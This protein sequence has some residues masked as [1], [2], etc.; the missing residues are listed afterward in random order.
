[1]FTK[2]ASIIIIF[3]PIYFI[4]SPSSRPTRCTVSTGPSIFRKWRLATAVPTRSWEVASAPACPSA[5]TVLRCS[6]LAR[7][8]GPSPRTKCPSKRSTLKVRVH[9]GSSHPKKLFLRVDFFLSSAG[10]ESHCL[11]VLLCQMSHP[12]WQQRTWRWLT[13]TPKN[14]NI[15]PSQGDY[16]PHWT[17]KNAWHA[18]PLFHSP[19]DLPIKNKE[20][21]FSFYAGQCQCPPTPAGWPKSPSRMWSWLLLVPAAWSPWTRVDTCDSGRR[22]WTRCSDPWWSGGTWLG[23]KMADQCRYCR[24]ALRKL[25][26]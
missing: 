22:V 21:K 5:T 1:M 3:L 15:F 9:R 20:I 24:N 16:Q 10:I 2:R 14:S 17:R 8:W 13:S 6:Q 12:H 23:Q 19:A 18:M 4:S 7:W 11:S 26:L 25:S